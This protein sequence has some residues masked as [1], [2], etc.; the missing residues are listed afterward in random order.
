MNYCR[1]A[2]QQAIVGFSAWPQK[3]INMQTGDEEP[4]EVGIFVSGILS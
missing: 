1:Q 3:Y 4:K 2:A